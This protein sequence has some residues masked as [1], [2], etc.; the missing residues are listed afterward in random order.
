MISEY[1]ANAVDTYL[2]NNVK[3]REIQKNHF[4]LINKMTVIY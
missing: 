2:P 1:M 4:Y 3:L